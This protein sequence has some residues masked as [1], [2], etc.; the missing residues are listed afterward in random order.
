M[1]TNKIYLECDGELLW[2]FENF[3]FNELIDVSRPR[4]LLENIKYHNLIVFDNYI[5]NF[6]IVKLSDSNTYINDVLVALHTNKFSLLYNRYVCDRC[7]LQKQGIKNFAGTWICPECLAVILLKLE[8]REY[9]I[10]DD[11]IIYNKYPLS[12][13]II[14]NDAA[15]ALNYPNTDLDPTINGYADIYNFYSTKSSLYTYRKHIRKCL[16]DECYI[17]GGLLKPESKGMCNYC[18]SQE[19]KALVQFYVN[20]Y[21]LINYIIPYFELKDVLLSIKHYYSALICDFKC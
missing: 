15:M 14:Y 8:R 19:Y 10:H 18:L 9:W 11:I 21:I 1:E 12:S 17:C 13:K 6:I 5:Y 7:F 20:E 2:N 4:K 16:G 3:N